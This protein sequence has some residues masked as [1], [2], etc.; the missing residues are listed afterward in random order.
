MC[1]TF[2]VSGLKGI[3]QRRMARNKSEKTISAPKNQKL[4]GEIRIDPNAKGRPM[5]GLNPYNPHFNKIGQAF[6]KL[7]IEHAKL[8][9]KRR[10]LD[11]GCGTGR[12]AKQLEQFMENGSY[13]G[14]DVNEHFI[15]Y[16][17]ETY[18]NKKFNFQRCDV[19]HDEFN[20]L[21]KINP[22]TFTFPY[23]DKSFDLTIAIA[24]F[25]HFE[26]P[27]VFRY[28]AE[29]MRVLKPNGIF[30]G[31]FLILTPRSMI[32]IEERDKHPFKFD[33]RTPNSWHEYTDRKLMN[34]A[35]PESGLRR[36]FINCR[37]MIKEPIRYG[38][39]CGSPVA[40][41]GHDVITAIKGGW[42]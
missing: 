22:Q 13:E 12:I 39:W 3:P 32:A 41:T 40:I 7:L 15:D 4:L 11:V 6:L 17:K 8:N 21:G 27:W 35:I 19:Q 42:D 34:V 37:L 2:R 1:F 30:F 31:T 25:N 16:C 36:Q 29:M 14:F 5:G 38:E 28:I 26:T 20:P 9:K 10:I 24:L 33:Y 23:D 18:T